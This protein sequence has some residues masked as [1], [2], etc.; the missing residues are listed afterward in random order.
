MS[1]LDELGEAYS[2]RNM[3]ASA[4]NAVGER[5][6]ALRE[7]RGLTQVAVVAAAQAAGHKLAQGLYAKVETGANR[8]STVERRRALA[9]GLGVPEVEFGRYLDG[10]IGMDALVGATTGTPAPP[11]ELRI[12]RDP[13]AAPR[14]GLSVW[15]ASIMAVAARDPERYAREDVDAALD[16]AADLGRLATA[17][18]DIEAHALEL[19]GAARGLRREGMTVTREAIYQRA[20]VGRL[21]SQ[22]EGGASAAAILDAEADRAAAREGMPGREG[23]AARRAQ[24]GSGPKKHQ[25]DDEE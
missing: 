5:V 22:Q 6:R 1:L 15:E 13:P 25:R 19:L 2:I 20:W 3:P 21:R 7:R 4:G 16:A 8:A 18:P 10:L 12:E 23:G 9:A 24:L 17:A 11:Q 14:E